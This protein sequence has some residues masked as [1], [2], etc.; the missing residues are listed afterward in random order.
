M[1]LRHLLLEQ[2][3]QSQLQRLI[4]EATPESRDIDY[5]RDTY[6]KKDGDHAK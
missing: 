5:K 2:I 3:D 6:G 1:S 4:D